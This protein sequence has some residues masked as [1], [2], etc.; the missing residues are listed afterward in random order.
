MLVYLIFASLCCFR[1][2]R[3]VTDDGITSPLRNWVVRNAPADVKKKAKEGITCPLCVSF[4]FA[5]ILSFYL[6]FL[7]I[8]LLSFVPLWWGAVWGA[9]I[10]WNQLFVTLTPK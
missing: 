5:G 7:D 9:S 2:T 10:L 1:I 6:F 4:Y 8:S 3:L